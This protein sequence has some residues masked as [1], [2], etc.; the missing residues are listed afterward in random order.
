MNDAVTASKRRRVLVVDDDK[1]Y[2]LILSV[3]LRSPLLEIVL[4]HTLASALE[5]LGKK[6]RFDAAIIDLHLPDATVGEVLDS[7]RR[8]RQMGSDAV[9]VITGVAGIN[10]F[11][12]HALEMGATAC[13]MKDEPQF[14]E[15]IKQAIC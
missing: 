15:K 3:W 4:A 2:A 8:F 10:G 7:V 12:E 5:W 11:R 1:E 9:V 13:L 6:L 14:V